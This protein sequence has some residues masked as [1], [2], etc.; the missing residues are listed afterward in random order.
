MF[1]NYIKKMMDREYVFEF[2]RKMQCPHCKDN[3]S[4]VK[5]YMGQDQGLR[6]PLGMKIN[7]YAMV[8]L[9]PN[10]ETIINIQQVGAGNQLFTGSK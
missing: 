6:A 9:C 1:G 8:F 4:W 5:G 3:I 10:C 7:I 2:G